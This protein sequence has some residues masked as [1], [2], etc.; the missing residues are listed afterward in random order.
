MADQEGLVDPQGLTRFLERS[1]PEFSGPFEITRTGEGQSCLTFLVSGDGWEFVLRRP[2]RGDLPPTAFDVTRE[3]RVMSALFGAGSPVP[4]PRPLILCE[5]PEVIGAK[6]YLME[7][8]EGVVVRRELPDLLSSVTERSRVSEDL[9][10]TLAKLH[11]VDY[12]AVGLADFGKPAGY[13]ERQLRR[14]NQLW[15]LAKFR[16]IP[17]IEKVGAWLTENLPQQGESS[18]IHGDYK[19]DNVILAPGPPARI[20]AVVD[21]EMSTLGDPL[22]D[23]GWILYFWRDPDDGTFGLASSTVTHEEGFYRRRDILQKYAEKTGRDVGE[24]LWY[25]ALG[26]WKIAII[27]EGSYRR[28]RSGIGDHPTFAALEQGVIALARR[29]QDAAEGDFGL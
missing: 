28:F 6:F 17:E 1:L 25:V 18:I 11:A 24:I 23:L 20:I 8:V 16:E 14:M 26:G 22:A 13:L 2:P 29:A 27:M 4:V 12:Q 10:D 9:I 15:E 19:L 21:W 3:Y 5:D 7:R